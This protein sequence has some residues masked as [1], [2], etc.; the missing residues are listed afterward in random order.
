MNEKV[1]I[2]IFKR[3]LS[4]EI[5]GLT[6]LEISTL[7]K[8]VSDKMGEIFNQHKNVA[9]GSKL[10]ILTALDFA[11]E[12]SKVKDASETSRRVLEHKLDHLTELL[13]ASLSSVEGRAE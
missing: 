7:A 2:E 1:D 12:L 8:Q 13:K 11:A 3:R 10:A 9:D 5:E 6:P 4:V